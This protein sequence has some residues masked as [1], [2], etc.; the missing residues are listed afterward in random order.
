[1]TNL[2]EQRILYAIKEGIDRLPQA[3]EEKPLPAEGINLVVDVGELATE[4]NVATLQRKY[5]HLFR[6][7]QEKLGYQRCAL[8]NVQSKK[9]VFLFGEPEE[10]VLH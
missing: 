8:V 5:G 3:T 7:L 6:D 2:D 10:L 1:V 4:E 9:V